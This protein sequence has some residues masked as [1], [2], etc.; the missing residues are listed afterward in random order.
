MNPLRAPYAPTAQE[1]RGRPFVVLEGVSGVGKSTLTRLL[2]KRLG[3]T[4]IH[5]L[6]QPHTSLS[7]AINAQLRPLPQFA[8][9]LSGLLHTSDLVREALSRG[10][11]VADRYASS[12]L[13]CHAAVNG[14]GLNQVKELFAPFKPY[15][16]VP[17]A[18]FYLTSSNHSLKQRMGTKTDVKQDDTDLLTVPGR[19][20]RLQANFQAV[21]DEDPS[22]IPLPTNQRSPDDLADLIV[23]HLE[24]QRA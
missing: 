2:A 7:P 8:F 11:V 20:A 14:V 17:D 6:P 23:K 21:A 15:L 3:A 18:T 10:P 12:V 22:A 24:A 9:Y 16:L 19:L 1:S 4:A 13:A 5:T